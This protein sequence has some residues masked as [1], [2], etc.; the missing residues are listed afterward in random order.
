MFEELLKI[1]EEKLR[2]SGDEVEYESVIELAASVLIEDTNEQEEANVKRVMSE[3]DA[4][5]K[6]NRERWPLVLE[7]YML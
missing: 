1:A 6:R 4:F 5:L 7:S 2:E 3:H